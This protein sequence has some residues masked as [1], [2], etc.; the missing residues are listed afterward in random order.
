M[1]HA[2]L[3]YVR[4]NRK[5]VERLTRDLNGSGIDTWT[6]KLI[7]PGNRWK[8]AIRR[9]IRDGAA[10]LA[11]FSP[12]AISRDRS[13]MHEELTVAIEMCRSMPTD[14]SW[15]IP[16]LLG[17]C[18]IPDRDIGAGETLQDL[19]WV[20]LYDDWDSGLSNIVATINSALVYHQINSES[21]G[22]PPLPSLRNQP[23]DRQIEAWKSVWRR[24]FKLKLASDELIKHANQTTYKEYAKRLERAIDR[25]G[26]TAFFFD[27]LDFDQLNKLLRYSMNLRLGKTSLLE[28]RKSHRRLPKQ[29]RWRYEARV[30]IEVRRQIHENVK[31]HKR[32]SDLL[33]DMQSS[34]AQRAALP[35][36]DSG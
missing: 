34:Y 14:R 3:S 23:S 10:F 24:L 9:A 26:K 20:E 33:F 2:F 21:S 8:K 1:P 13:Y 29:S 36:T 35:A 25:V 28:I 30:A 32:F 31:N 4:E 19:Q 6:D 7:L 12:E 16:V 15:L 22:A 5:Q 18:E 27:K 11:C 17:P